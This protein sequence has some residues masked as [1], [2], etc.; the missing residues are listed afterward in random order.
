MPRTL[1]EL[2]VEAL[3]L[4]PEARDELATRLRESL[5]PAPRQAA[6]RAV[7]KKPSK[8]AALASRYR[9]NTSLRG[10]SEKLNALV[11]EFR[12]EFAL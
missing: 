1:Q 10:N 7:A 2:E 6:L 4:P 8:W 9:E 5:K 3:A 12:E 11:R